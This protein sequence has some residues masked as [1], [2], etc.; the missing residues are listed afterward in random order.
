MRVLLVQPPMILSKSEIPQVSP[1][2][3]LAYIASV[4]RKHSHT[5]EIFDSVIQEPHGHHLGENIH[6]G[7]DWDSIY[8]KISSYNPEIV[9][10]S[11]MFTCQAE[12]MHQ[13]A[14]LV[15]GV[16]ASIV[17]ITGG[18]H[19]S[20]LPAETIKDENVDFVVIGEGEDIVLRLVESLS[21]QLPF[22]EIDGIAFR[23]DGQIV[24]NPETGFIRN[25]DEL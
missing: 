25:L 23:K 18:A 22:E 13:V 17:T 11:S 2:L 12:C 16:D 1:P 4:L 20:A 19:P 21:N 7:A 15:K 9:G 10:I 6:L 5:V 8:S 14:R 3:G 24:I